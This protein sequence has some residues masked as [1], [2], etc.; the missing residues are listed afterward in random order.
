MIGIHPFREQ[1]NKL[2]QLA[3]GAAFLSAML[4]SDEPSDCGKRGPKPKATTAAPPAPPKPKGKGPIKRTPTSAFDPAAK[5][6]DVYQIERACGC[7][8]RES[9]WLE[10][11]G[12]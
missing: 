2:L 5:D 6:E 7:G 9:Q 3:G 4:C 8:L 1:P 12:C 10:I 11:C